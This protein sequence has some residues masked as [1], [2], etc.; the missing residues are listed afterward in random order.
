MGRSTL[1]RIVGLVFVFGAHSALAQ[2][3]DVL[4]IPVRIHDYARLPEGSIESAQQRVR[5]LYAAIGVHPVWAET[6][7]PPDQPRR[8]LDRDPQEWSIIILNP[9]MSRRLR[10]DATAVGLA[11]VTRLEG[12]KVAYILSDRV[13]NVAAA[14]ATDPADVLGMIIAHELGHLL[15]PSGAHSET[16]LM[17]PLWQV[18]DFRAVDPQLL[19]FTPA[20]AN[21]VR[22]RLSQTL[23]AAGDERLA[24]LQTP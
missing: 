22:R 7:R 13:S 19:R 1:V 12:G 21:A 5:D 16:G 17:R 20:Q 3:N 18:L 15:L 14:S 8:M 9:A 11:V 4:S 2:S 24:A 23:S 6:M 10:V